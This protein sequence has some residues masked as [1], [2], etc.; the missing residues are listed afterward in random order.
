MTRI[1]VMSLML[2]LLTVYAVPQAKAHNV[3]LTVELNEWYS[4]PFVYSWDGAEY[5]ME[6][7]IYSVGRNAEREYT[8]YLFLNKAVVP[9]DGVYSFEIRE[10]PS[11]E[12]WTDMLKLITIDHPAGVRVGV[13]SSGNVHS[14]ANPL[15]PDSA[16]DGDGIDVWSL[17]S[18][19]DDK[20]AMML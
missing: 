6:N 17:I 15:P 8:D 13:D 12:S 3:L 10:L 18:S 9:K 14:Y 1:G 11:E 4:C 16:Y 20:G 7:D 5:Q 19:R 2:M